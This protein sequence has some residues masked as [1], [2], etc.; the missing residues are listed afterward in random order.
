MSAPSASVLERFDHE[1]STCYKFFFFKSS[2]SG[3]FQ[4]PNIGLASIKSPSTWTDL[5]E[6]YSFLLLP[7]FF[8]FFHWKTKSTPTSTNWSKVGVEFDKMNMLYQMKTTHKRKMLLRMKTTSTFKLP[9][10]GNWEQ[11]CWTIFH[12]HV[13]QWFLRYSLNNNQ[14]LKKKVSKKIFLVPLNLNR[15]LAFFF[16][17]VAMWNALKVVRCKNQSNLKMKIYFAFIAFI[18]QCWKLAALLMRLR[19]RLSRKWSSWGH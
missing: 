16:I 14:N 12:L 15:C 3:C 18:T 6:G 4:K 10:N 11:P 8:F 2:A 7:S 9:K 13:W 19:G 17:P 5:G 1:S